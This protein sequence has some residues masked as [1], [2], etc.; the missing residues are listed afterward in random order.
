[1][2]H[3]ARA[4]GAIGPGAGAAVLALVAKLKD[5]DPLVRAHSVRTLGLIGEPSKRYVK[6]IGVLIADKDEKVRR[7]VPQALLRMKP[8]RSVTIPLF[9]KILQD[10]DASVRNMVLHAV[11]ETG[12]EAVPLLLDALDQPQS[13]YWACL[14]L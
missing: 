11:A 14:A 7:E 5:T 2:Y 12:A 9:T 13:R 10:G 3:A 6:E 8:D 4:L 1:R